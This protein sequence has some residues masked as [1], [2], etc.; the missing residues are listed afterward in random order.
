MIKPRFRTDKMRGPSDGVISNRDEYETKTG[1]LWEE[2]KRTEQTGEEN[3]WQ[4]VAGLLVQAADMVVVVPP[5]RRRSHSWTRCA[6]RR[7]QRG[8]S[9]SRV[10]TKF[11]ANGTIDDGT[12]LNKPTTR[13]LNVTV[14]GDEGGEH[15]LSMRPSCV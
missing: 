8:T 3:R 6:T 14:H 7:R 1:E 5:R 2:T 10:G 15:S 9:W 4:H 12:G 13:K 11:G